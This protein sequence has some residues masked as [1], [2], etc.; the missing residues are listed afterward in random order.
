M[1][2]DSNGLI[3][4]SNLDGGDTAAREGFYF[5]ALKMRQNLLINNSDC[6][7]KSADFI[8]AVNRLVTSGGLIR[9]PA[10]PYNVPTDTS[11]DQTN[12]MILACGLWGMM[13]AVRIMRPWGG[14]LYQN[15]DLAGPVDWNVYSRATGANGNVIGDLQA[16]GGG[17][18]RCSQAK[19]N[20]DDV[21]DDLNTLLI[22][23]FFYICEPTSLVK[24]AL[25]YYLSNR[26]P[27]YGTTKPCVVSKD[28]QWPTWVPEQ[29]PVLGAISWYNRPF[30][31]YRGQPASGGNKEMVDIWRPL[32][33]RFRADLGCPL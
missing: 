28:P 32:I 1:Y 33:S 3:V 25:A 16:F 21:G 15:H 18:I 8:N 27:N 24:S 19:K 12:P 5:G 4:Q 6:S 20:Q 13:D 9:N 17:V 29:D 10:P 11:R 26:P 22:L 30:D 14:L 7:L 31:V 2:L 23:S